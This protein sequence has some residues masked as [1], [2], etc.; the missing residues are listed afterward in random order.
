MNNQQPTT[1]HT[2]TILEEE[3]ME[4]APMEEEIQAADFMVEEVK[5]EVLEGPHVEILAAT[6]ITTTRREQLKKSKT[7][8]LIVDQEK[9]LRNVKK[10]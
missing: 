4:E 5:E 6:G 3:V 8:S 7:M 1:A 2:T 9:T 10:S